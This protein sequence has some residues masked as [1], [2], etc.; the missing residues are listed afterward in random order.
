ML[1]RSGAQCQT[2]TTYNRQMMDR[3]LETYQKPF[4]SIWVIMAC[5]AVIGFVT[6]FFTRELTLEKEELGRQ[7]LAAEAR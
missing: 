3:L 1:G 7:S 2:H 4:Q 5:V 6:S